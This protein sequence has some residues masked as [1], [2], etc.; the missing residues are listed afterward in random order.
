MSPSETTSE[1]A[2]VVGLPARAPPAAAPNRP[3]LPKVLRIVPI[4][5]TLATT[6][7]AIVLG[8]AM[9]NAYMGAP[10]TRDGT[11]RNYV[12]TMAP[13]VAGRI[14]ELPVR[15][16][17]LVQ[18][19]DVL[20]VIEP[21][22]YQ[23]AV[24]LA[25]AA[26]QQAQANAQIIDAQ[27]TVQEAQIAASQALVEQAQAAVTFS[28]EQAARYKDLAQREYGTVQMERPAPDRLP[29]SATRKRGGHDRPSLRYP[30]PSQGQFGAYPN[31]RSGG[32]L[33]DQSPGPAGRLRHRR[34]ERDLARRCRF[35]LGG[36]LFRG[37]G[38]G[39]DPRGRPGERQIVRGEVGN[40]A[41]AINVPNAQPDQQGLAIV[42]PIFTWVRLAQR[43]PVRIRIKEVPDGVRLVAGMT[44]TVEVE[45]R[46]G[47]HS[48]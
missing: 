10:W 14:V 9:W 3:R 35:L 15:D 18:K 36:R 31:P 33:G 7:V 23:I 29:Q 27:I 21:T 41:R 6:A 30:R 12:V 19:G 44:A 37:N 20:L 17:Q 24:R 34:K 16:N 40:I 32:R 25:E 8:W 4:L 43:V 45:P 42:N 11:V 46:R 38:A 26:V 48:N 47:R 39:L 5:I 13:E 28:Q 1:H 22:D 2:K